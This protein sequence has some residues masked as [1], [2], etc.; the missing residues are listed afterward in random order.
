[1]DNKSLLLNL[2]LKKRRSS[3]AFSLKAPTPPDFS[4]EVG[5]EHFMEH[6]LTRPVREVFHD[7]QGFLVKSVVLD[8]SVWVVRSQHDGEQLASETGHPALLLDEILSQK[9]K[10]QEEARAALLPCLITGTKH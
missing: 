2:V 3:D 9:G 7:F 8:L 6:Y 10:T 1:M 4:G 5:A